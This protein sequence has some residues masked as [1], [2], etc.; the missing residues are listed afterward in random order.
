M[1]EVGEK[2]GDKSSEKSG[3][4]EMGLGIFDEETTGEE[5]DIT[6]LKPSNKFASKQDWLSNLNCNFAEIV[7][8]GLEVSL[9]EKVRNKFETK[10]KL[11]PKENMAMVHSVNHHILLWI[12]IQR[13]ESSLCRYVFNVCLCFHV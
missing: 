13:P 7:I 12:G 9:R 3:S 5:V 4:G 8:G 2:R 6:K 10:T 1:E 11:T